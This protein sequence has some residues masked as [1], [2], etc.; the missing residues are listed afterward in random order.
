MLPFR[1]SVEGFPERAKVARRSHNLQ[2]RAE[3]CL[4]PVLN[5]DPG[6]EREQERKRP[7]D[8]VVVGV[9]DLSV[10]HVHMHV[11]MFM[12]VCARTRTHPIPQKH[13][14]RVYLEPSRG[15][16]TSLSLP[17]GTQLTSEE[18]GSRVDS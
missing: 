4:H 9:V 15:T 16:C 12:R 5:S 13:A 7:R 3:T 14:P 8:S 17:A 10:D 6:I 1:E 18:E 2:V 11:H